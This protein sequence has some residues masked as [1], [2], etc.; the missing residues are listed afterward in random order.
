MEERQEQLER[1]ERQDAVIRARIDLVAR[2][3]L[4]RREPSPS[5]SHER[6]KTREI[7]TQTDKAVNAVDTRPNETQTDPCTKSTDGADDANNTDD[8]VN[9]PSTSASAA[10]VIGMPGPSNRNNDFES[11]AESTGEQQSAA[12]GYHRSQ[13]EAENED[14]QPPAVM[15]EPEQ[16][17]E[18]QPNPNVEPNP[19]AEADGQE[20]RQRLI[21]IHQRR[22]DDDDNLQNRFR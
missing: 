17:A 12:S 5:S 10:G 15:A 11:K 22:H 8:N 14:E 19:N 3:E 4:R 21:I 20:R 2:A 13:P 7:E 18:M 1:R 9:K 16:A 6:P